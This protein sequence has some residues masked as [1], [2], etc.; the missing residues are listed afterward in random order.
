MALAASRSN[1]VAQLLETAE[2]ETVQI[3]DHPEKT[4]NV[5]EAVGSDSSL[6]A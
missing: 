4:L 6:I 3:G 1:E 2:E 5:G